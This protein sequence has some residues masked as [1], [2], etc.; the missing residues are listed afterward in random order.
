ME[1]F[2]VVL[3]YR[4]AN[5]NMSLEKQT[6]SHFLCVQLSK[7]AS[8]L[9]V[10][11]G[12]QAMQVICFQVE[13]PLRPK[14]VMDQPLHRDCRGSCMWIDEWCYLLPKKFL[15]S[16]RSVHRSCVLVEYH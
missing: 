12:G 10:P 6:Q 7:T 15:K 4:L 14:I 1:L 8:Q 9:R 13:C 11:I 2:A 5:E 3:R 16:P